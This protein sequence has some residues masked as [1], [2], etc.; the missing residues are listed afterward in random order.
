MC[1]FDEIAHVRYI[2]ILTW[3]WGFRDKI[4]NFWQR[5]CLAI[6]RGDLGAKKTKPNIENYDHKA[7]DADGVILQI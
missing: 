3:L 5:H 7:S 6:P 4:A 2:K 1:I